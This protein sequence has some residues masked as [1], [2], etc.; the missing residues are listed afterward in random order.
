MMKA[1]DN[2]IDVT[3]ADFEYQV[4]AYS[5]QVPVV[6]DF[7]AGWCVPCKALS[8][9]LEKLAEE[10][11]GAFRLAKIDVDANSNLAVR[12]NVRGIPAVKAF[13]EGQIV[14]EFAGLLPEA[15]L[16]EFIRALAPSKADL[17]IEKALTMLDLHQAGSAEKGFRQALEES[18]AN[19]AAMLG[20][21]KSLLLQG[22]AGE[23][24]PMLHGFPASKEYG[25]VENL[26]PLVETMVRIGKAAS[27]ES[28]PLEP[29]YF[30][31]LRLVGRGNVLAAM[32]GLMDILRQDKHYRSDEARRVM[33]GLFELLKADDPLTRQYRSEFASV[34]F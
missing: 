10:G 25:S 9:M 18:P 13:R 23:A 17:L 31:A 1:S 33:V 32:D 2:I 4:I 8:P 34:L 28:D 24:A 19:P 11:G 5:Q 15:R 22:R 3:E 21:I 27:D 16:I 6:V 29:A 7:W 12:F 26:R 20:L 14:S 30:N